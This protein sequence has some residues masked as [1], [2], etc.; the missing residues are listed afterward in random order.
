VTTGARAV[1]LDVAIHPD[2]RIVAAGVQ[3]FGRTSGGLVISYNADGSLDG[4]A[5][6]GLTVPAWTASAVAIQADGRIVVGGH[7]RYGPGSSFPFSD[8]VLARSNLDG[9]PDTSFDGD[10]TVRSGLGSMVTTDFGPGPSARA[11]DVAIQDDG[12][13]VGA[14]GVRS[15]VGSTIA[16]VRHNPDGSFDN[17]FGGDGLVLTDLNASDR[18][19]LAIQDDG[20][21]VVAGGPSG[22]FALSRYRPDGTLD[23]SFDGD[24]TVTTDFG[25][26][27]SA[28]AVA[29]QADGKVVAG[30]T[31]GGAGADLALA[32]YLADGVAALCGSPATLVGTPGNDRLVGTPGGDIIA[33]LGGNDVIVGGGGDDVLCGGAG[34]DVLR[35]GAGRDFLDGGVLGADQ[36]QAGPDDDRLMGG[37]GADILWSAD[38]GRVDAHGGAGDDVIHGLR[39]DDF[40]QG[41]QGNDT[42]DGGEGNDFLDGGVFGADP[43]HARPDDDD[44][45]GGPGDD[46]LWS[47]DA[48]RVDAEGGN[49][50][51]VIH[52]LI[53][54]DV[55]IG[56]AGADRV[57]G[58]AGDD[59]IDVVDSVQGNDVADGAAGTDTCTADPGDVQ[60]SCP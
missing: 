40:L 58:G 38:F 22:D 8:Y 28:E 34:N 10:G 18:A 32:R 4:M 25:G 56:G 30:G 26:S 11:L 5:P 23:T 1:A 7:D 47:A 43:A 13:I 51:D 53:G 52:G 27:D 60:L 9:S 24:G 21:I 37:P 6:G 57:L 19:S 39:G 54:H 45:F 31:T 49:G 42:L 2:G 16:L 44:L 41:G 3:S 59:R 12:R 33:G 55:L 14:A 46:I 50:G 36:A 17:T 48:G 35:G 20:R 29:V 15:D